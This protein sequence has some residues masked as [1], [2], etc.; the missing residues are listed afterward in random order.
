MMIKLV[1]EIKELEKGQNA[2][3]VM[4]R[5]EKE[6]PTKMEELV[7]SRLSPV[8]K[9]ALTEWGLLDEPGEGPSI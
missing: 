6:H 4:F 9:R 8:L 1:V 5:T 7:E 3:D 2:A